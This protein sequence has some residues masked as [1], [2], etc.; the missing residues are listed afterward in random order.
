MK[1]A[2]S[3]LVALVLIFLFASCKQPAA[4]ETTQLPNPI[5]DVESSADFEP[6]GVSITTPEG[7]ENVTYSIIANV[8]AQINFTLDGRAYTTAP[9]R[10]RTTSP[11]Y[12]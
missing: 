3:I 6:L 11:A 2:F 7:A 4:E 10:Q 5:V 8:T 1:K 12:T 9:Q